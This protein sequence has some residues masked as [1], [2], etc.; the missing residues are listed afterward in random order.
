[1]FSNLI[2][3]HNN[4]QQM[5]PPTGIR[6]VHEAIVVV[7]QRIS[8]KSVLNCW[9]AF[10]FSFISNIVYDSIWFIKAKVAEIATAINW[11]ELSIS[12][13]YDIGCYGNGNVSHFCATQNSDTHEIYSYG[14]FGGAVPPHHSQTCCFAKLSFFPLRITKAQQ[15]P[16]Q[17]RKCRF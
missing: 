2:R 15:Q 11:K 9:Q 13:V 12:L 8:I 4:V 16:H 1:M 5:H 14:L 10:L 3:I 7:K 17:Q 6:V